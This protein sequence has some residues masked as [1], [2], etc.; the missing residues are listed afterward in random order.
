MTRSKKLLI[1]L[2]A[3]AVC[4]LGYFA[5]SRFL[6][7]STSDENGIE[8][9]NVDSSEIESVKWLYD[10]TELE[11]KP[12]DEK[13]WYCVQDKNFPLD[14]DMAIEMINAVCN[15]NAVKKIAENPDELSKYGINEPKVRVY[16]TADGAVTEYD[17]GNY[18]EAS[19]Y[20]YMMYTNDPALYYID[21]SLYDMFARDMLDIIEYE[22]LPEIDVQDVQNLT[23]ENGK[24]K[25]NITYY[26]DGK[27]IESETYNY[28]DGGSSPVE[29]EKA[30]EL[31]T[32]F[33]NITWNSCAAYNV[34]DKD[35]SEYGLDN[36]SAVFTIRYKSDTEE[37]TESESK[38][39]SDEKSTYSE[40]TLII[41]K[42][43]ES[44]KAEDESAEA[45]PSYYAMIKGGDRVY[46]L[47]DSAAEKY[48]EYS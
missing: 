46:T 45:A 16:V 26:P 6:G 38:A 9:S 29:T 4:V 14:Q 35:L 12:L 18:N 21:S 34:T 25:A 31:I 11:I 2:A 8:I 23:I 37:D 15:V 22:A 24:T 28:I 36:P 42:T 3:L 30:R 1:L 43:A 10:G 41:G 39:V 32:G 33:V 47:S 5:A 48:I 27:E 44:E 40:A 19:G 17:I 13:T 7:K 20:Y